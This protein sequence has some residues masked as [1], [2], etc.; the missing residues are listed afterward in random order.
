M[1]T[2]Q[3]YMLQWLKQ[4]VGIKVN[5]LVNAEKSDLNALVKLGL[6]KKIRGEY[7]LVVDGETNDLK[8][9]KSWELKMFH[10]ID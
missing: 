1:T 5:C 2:G 4:S 3:K 10:N 8:D 9:L 7:S 6:A